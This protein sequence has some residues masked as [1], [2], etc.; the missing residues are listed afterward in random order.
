M[1][2]TE[3]ERVP[4]SR[5]LYVAHP[6]GQGKERRKA[7]LTI[8][9]TEWF[10]WLLAKHP[11]DALSCSWPMYAACLDEETSRSRGLRD[12]LAVLAKCD[13]IILCGLKITEGMM[14]ELTSYLK[15]RNE[16]GEPTLVYNYT[17]SILPPPKEHFGV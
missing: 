7:N 12:D 16:R 4:L 3:L 17:G 11:N 2:E 6:L 9:Q 10:P 5:V 1:D 8:L 13:G 15:R 14:E